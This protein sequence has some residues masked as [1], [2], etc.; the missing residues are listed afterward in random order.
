MGD[1]VNL[2]WPNWVPLLDYPIYG[3]ATIH[4]SERA[5]TFSCDMISV[6]EKIEGK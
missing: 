2:F 4:L 3:G 6:I 1:A 5:G